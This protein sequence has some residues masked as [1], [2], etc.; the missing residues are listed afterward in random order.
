MVSARDGLIEDLSKRYEQMREDFKY[1]L[2]LIGQRDAEINRLH[3]TLNSNKNEFERL[4]DEKRQ[5]VNKISEME[6][7]IFDLN[8]TYNKEKSQH[9]VN[10]LIAM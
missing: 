7:S 10:G 8:D 4:E 9:Q 1:N 3:T 6:I 2:N 5:F